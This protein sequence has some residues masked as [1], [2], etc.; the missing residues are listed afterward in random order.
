MGGN[1]SNSS[2]KSRGTS[3]ST[4]AKPN[5]LFEYIRGISSLRWVFVVYDR[6]FTTGHFLCHSAW[7]KGICIKA[8]STLH[9]T[10]QVVFVGPDSRFAGYVFACEHQSGP[11]NHSRFQH[12]IGLTTW[13]VKFWSVTSPQSALQDVLHRNAL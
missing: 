2:H 4:S 6:L 3:I 10:C 8:Q 9:D 5:H 11:S 7:V 1:S 12:L 13:G